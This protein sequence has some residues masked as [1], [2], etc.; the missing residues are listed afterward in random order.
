[1]MSRCCSPFTCCTITYFSPTIVICHRD[2]LSIQAS[3]PTTH[4]KY[5][6]Y[7]AIVFCFFF[8]IYQCGAFCH[9]FFCILTQSSILEE[10]FMCRA[11]CLQSPPT[12]IPNIF[13][14]CLQH[15]CNNINLQSTLNY[16]MLH[17]IQ[18]QC[19]IMQQRGVYFFIA[20]RCGI[21][22]HLF[23]CLLTPPHQCVRY[24]FC[25]TSFQVMYI[26]AQE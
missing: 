8:S 4:I 7:Y 26:W 14:F 25:A 2:M 18:E 17:L 15:T 23:F 3:P 11:V 16:C 5:V 10:L 13:T 24:T 21:F 9:L 12:C 22:C 1:M 19:F 6:I 20:H